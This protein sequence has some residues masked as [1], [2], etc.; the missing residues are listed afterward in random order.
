MPTQHLRSYWPR[1]VI[2]VIVVLCGWLLQT[3]FTHMYDE[4]VKQRV[5]IDEM[6]ECAH[7]IE[8]RV[9]KLETHYEVTVEGLKRDQAEMKKDLGRMADDVSEIKALMY[10][11]LNS[12]GRSDGL[13]D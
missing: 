5:S 7:V 1:Y 3:G 8:N 11:T 2:G 13:G 4:Q 6:E 12:G 9:T 10:Q